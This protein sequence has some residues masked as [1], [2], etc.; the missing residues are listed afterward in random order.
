M[1]DRLR[2]VSPIDGRVVCERPLAGEDEIARTLEEARAAQQDW[3]AL[4]KAPSTRLSTAA[5]RSAS[6]RT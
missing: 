6:A 5:A 2:C 4:K 3:P 1:P